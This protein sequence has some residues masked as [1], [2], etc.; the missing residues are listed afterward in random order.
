MEISLETSIAVT[1]IALNDIVRHYPL[2]TPQQHFV[3]NLVL[4]LAKEG[5]YQL[6]IIS[7]IGCSGLFPND[8]MPLSR[9]RG[10]R[11]LR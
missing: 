11:P 3:E 4:L 10:G 5:V 1:E 9:T 7:Q 8:Q 2:I 6:D